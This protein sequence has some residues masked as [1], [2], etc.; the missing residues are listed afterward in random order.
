MV[1]D[2][3]KKIGGRVSHLQICLLVLAGCCICGMA[4]PVCKSGNIALA[5]DGGLFL[6]KVGV[7]L[8]LGDMPFRA[9][10]VN[11]IEI[12]HYFSIFGDTSLGEGLLRRAAEHGVKVIRYPAMH[13]GKRLIDLWR[14]EKELFWQGQD[15]L[16]QA[17]KKYGIQLIPSFMFVL[18]DFPSILQA[19]QEDLF[20]PGRPTNLLWKGFVGDFL[21]RYR[22]EPTILMWEVANE[23]NLYADRY[24]IYQFLTHRLVDEFIRDAVAFMHAVDPNHLVCSGNSAPAFDQAPTPE[25]LAEEF[26]RVN[27]YVD[28]ACIHT[29]P[30]ATAGSYYGISEAEYL[31]I[32]IKA[33]REI[34][35]IPVFIGEFGDDY[36]KNPRSPFCIEVFET[37]L[38]YEVPLTMIWE[39]EV[40]KYDD[41]DNRQVYSVDPRVTPEMAEMVK[42]YARRTAQAG[43]Q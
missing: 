39:W 16:I 6:R 5:S 14:S 21:A 30:F 42:E 24:P 7:D 38:K 36:R 8:Y 35:Q 3:V 15:R 20:V 23:L 27:K 17:A 25:A 18:Y 4:D 43:Q 32:M 33:S 2:L 11:S 9:V 40:P 34:L 13:L 29:Y 26:V 22:N 19:S 31:A 41:F 10:G 28:V 12:V 37:A 1:L